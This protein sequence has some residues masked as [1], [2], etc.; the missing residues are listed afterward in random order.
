VVLPDTSIIE[1]KMKS[2]TSKVAVKESSSGGFWQTISKAATSFW[3]WLTG[4]KPSE[5]RE[6]VRKISDEIEKLLTPMLKDMSS[7]LAASFGSFLEN[8]AKDIKKRIMD[9]TNEV[10][11]VYDGSLRDLKNRVNSQSS[12][13]TQEMEKAKIIRRM[14]F[15]MTSA[16]DTLIATID[17]EVKD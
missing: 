12:K 17:M 11:R 15:D 13:M 3:N 9:A 16:C 2:V 4:K 8:Q 6:Q 1:K 7:L 14:C 5:S 10:I